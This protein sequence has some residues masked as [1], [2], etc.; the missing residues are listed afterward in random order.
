MT[1]D[2]DARLRRLEGVSVLALAHEV[3]EKVFCETDS[4][5]ENNIGADLA[6]LMGAIIDLRFPDDSF[7][8]WS[9]EGYGD[10]GPP[11]LLGILKERFPADHAVWEFIFFFLGEE[12]VLASGT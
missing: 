5:R 3:W 2:P 10:D 9:P 12:D 7:V 6:Y 11:A 8:D 1:H 4:F